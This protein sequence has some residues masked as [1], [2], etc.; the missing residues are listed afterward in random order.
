V[1]KLYIDNLSSKYDKLSENE[2]IERNLYL[3]KLLTGEIIGPLT[4]FPNIDKEWLINY[5]EEQI[6]N[7]MPKTT[8]INYVE[9]S[10]MANLDNTAIIYFDKKISFR[11]L[12]NMIDLCAASFCANGIRKGDIVTLCMPFT[13][14]VI[15]SIYALNK[16]GA[17]A[18]MVHPLSSENQIKTYI[19]KVK[20][21][22]V[23]SIDASYN[24]VNSIRN[25]TCVDKVI[26]VSPSDSMPLYMKPIYPLTK[27]AAKI[28]DKK[29]LITW[30]QFIKEGYG[31]EVEAVPYEEDRPAVIMQTGGTTGPSKGAVLTNDNFNSMVEQFKANATNF[32]KGDTMLTIMPPFHGFGLCSSCHL[33]LS[34]GVKIVLIPKIN[35]NEIDKLIMKYKINHIVAVPTL[36]KGLKMVVR[37]KQATGKLKNFNLK[38]LKYAVSGG[39]LAKNG[40]EDDTDLFFKENGADIKLSKGYGLTEAVA[41]VTFA[42][43]NMK[44]ENNNGI[45][46]VATNIKIVDQ[47]TD[48]I[49]PNNMVGEICVRGATVMKEYYNNIE[50]TVATIKDG[51]LHTGDLGYMNN[52]RLYFSERKGN[53]IISSGV[54]VYPSEIEQ[55]IESHNKVAACAVIGIDHPYK[56]EVP[57]A[58]IELKPGIEATDEI[59]NEIQQLCRQN[60][61]R[62]SQPFAYEYRDKLP[63]TLLGKISHNELKKEEERRKG[64]KVY[65]KRGN[66]R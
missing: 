29:N 63:Q 19:N 25:D 11:K 64:Y 40:F 66:K 5:T 20:S 57:K 47:E 28:D 10:N 27:D 2:E 13:P 51:W 53:M 16:I 41:G 54:N 39:S 17:V 36:F 59:D 55:V 3:R 60:L 56:E 45:P 8:M 58:F 44:E 38:G 12:F 7:K 9:K 34:L 49:L 62:Y 50:E 26:M 33:P 43:E 30:K 14:E 6:K 18:N 46:M 35:I 22:L 32:E 24:K 48:E 65:E 42:D 21:R 23:I 15:I 31:T 1:N 4:D 61:D 37:K 52:G